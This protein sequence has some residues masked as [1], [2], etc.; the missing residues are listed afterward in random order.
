[1]TP[2]SVMMMNLKRREDKYWFM[3][4]GLRVLGFHSGY[5]I[6]RFNSHD[7][8]D[9]ADVKSLCQ[10]AVDDRFPHFENPPDNLYR[11]F[12][13]WSWT[14]QAAL[15][16]IAGMDKIVLLLVDD[17]L[18]K[19]HWPAH[20]LDALVTECSSRE[21]PFRILQLLPSFDITESVSHKPHTSMLAKG[22]A[23]YTDEGVILSSEGAKL[24]LD[25]YSK[26]PFVHPNTVYRQVG[27][28]QGEDNYG[29]WHTLDP[30]ID[31]HGDFS[32][33]SDLCPRGKEI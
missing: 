23:G 26:N 14:Y 6:I 13:V 30:I 24:V 9:Y 33:S 17:M 16:E 1:M 8:Q 32:S 2:I 18:P 21:Y 5:E 25:E 11:K 27:I 28:E 31:I 22:L 3:L 29:L 12:L 15:R 20:R 10:A 4:G 7:Y 19:V